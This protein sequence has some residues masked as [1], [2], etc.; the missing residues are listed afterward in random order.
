[1]TMLDPL[2]EARRG[3]SLRPCGGRLPWT[4]RWTLG[5]VCVLTLLNSAGLLLLLIQ[6]RELGERVARAES[7]LEEI[8]QSSVVEF[9]T[10]MSRGQEE[11]QKELYQYSRNKRSQEL[12]Q[13]Q[14]LEQLELE[15]KLAEQS[16]MGIGE[17][18]A[19]EL[20]GEPNQERKKH[21]EDLQPSQS[22]QRTQMQDGMMMMMTYSMVP[23]DARLSQSYRWTNSLAMR[24][25]LSCQPVCLSVL[26]ACLSACLSCLSVCPVL[27]ACL[28]VLSCLPACLSCLSV[29]L[30]VCLSCQPVCPAC[31]SVLSCLPACLSCLSVCLP[32]CLSVLPACLPACLSCPVL[33]CLPACLSVLSCPVLSCLPA[34]LSCLPVCSACLSCPVCLSCL[35]VCLSVLPVCLSVLPACLSCPVC[36]SCLSVLSVCP[37]C[38]SCPVCLSYPV[39]PVCLSSSVCLS[40]LSVSSCPDRLLLLQVKVLLDLCNST[41]G[42][43]LT[44]PPGPPGLPG[45]DGM[46]GYNGTDGI[47]GLP[48]EP[49][50]HGKRGKKGPPGEKGE[51]GEPGEPGEKGDPGPPGE[52]GEPS[53]DVI[54][55]GP[56]GPAGP[57]GV[58]GPMGPPGLP[59]P[60][61]PQGPPRPGRNRSHRAHL[62]TDQAPEVHTGFLHTVPNDAQGPANKAKAIKSECI[63]KSVQS[64][65]NLAKMSTTYGAWMKDTALRDDENIWVAEHFSGRI[66]KEYKSIAALQ[67]S[68]SQSIDVRKFF[69]GCSHLVH[70]G[71]LYYHIAGTFTIAKFDL[72]TN[73]LHTL[74]IENARYHNL[75][76]LLNN[77]KTYFKVAADE[78]GLWLIFASSI[79]E[80]I[81]VAQLDEKTFSITTYIN[82]SYPR[83]KAGNAF[84]ACGVLYVTDTKDTRVTFAFDLLKQKP[85]NVSFDLWSPSGVLAMLSYSPK[86]RQLYVWDGGYVKSYEVHFLSD[87]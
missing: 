11:I 29:C 23:I 16:G 8:A 49:G 22:H 65:R 19:K 82:T 33:S 40:C 18:L 5:S 58:P 63:I 72:R 3:G 64:P 31:L 28:S 62:H 24:F 84:I 54:V 34:C 81:V 10:E 15:E 14:V 83:S 17:D 75:S 46:P 51:P 36:L 27:S 47:P 26:P 66:V 77:S 25:C 78:S 32:V 57:P 2:A 1:M 21:Q 6:S 79:D 41:K 56:P 71:S 76:Y 39:L 12:R 37:A 42:F 68:S 38:L 35:S 59:G 60:P 44:G 69:Q 13:E 9:M 7:R 48:G 50:T 86:D 55:E 4:L 85:L 73:R 70:N 74:A 45:V 61:G 67:N 87:E 43:C 20:H 80:N 30:S 53:N 52:K